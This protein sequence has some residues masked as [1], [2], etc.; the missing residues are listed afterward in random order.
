M[1]GRHEQSIGITTSLAQVLA[2][3]LEDPRSQRPALE[4]M[5][6]TGQP[7]GK[8]YPTL[9]RLQQAGWVRADWED[10]EPAVAGRPA[11][12]HYLLTAEGAAAARNALALYAAPRPGPASRS[13]AAGAAGFAPGAGS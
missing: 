11:R 10:V 1:V 12:R 8:L 5:R 6:A 2:A 7:S 9:I 3:L 4:L 13:R